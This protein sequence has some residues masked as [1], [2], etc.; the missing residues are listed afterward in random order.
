MKITGVY[1]SGT[2]N[3]KWVADKLREKL[4]V[5]GHEV[6]MCSVEEY[7]IEEM[8]EKLQRSDVIGFLYPGYGCDMP[9]LYEQYLEAL[10]IVRLNKEPKAFSIMTAGMYIADGALITR[11]LCEK[12]GADLMWG[13]VVIMPCNFDTPVPFF[14]IPTDQRIEKM[15][16]K[17]HKKLETLVVNIEE[18][19]RDFDGNDF[20]NLKTGKL[21]RDGWKKSMKNYDIK[22]NESKCISCGQCVKLC[23]AKNLSIEEKGQPV[24]T[25]GNCSVCLR[26]INACPTLAIRMFSKHGSRQFRQYHGPTSK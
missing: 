5:R 11:P 1:F 6:E 18:G 26:C 17:A 2:G 3:T 19:N 8:S 12:I 15:K 25:N 24:K 20:F 10:S 7:S 4:T 9:L 13:N 14:K 23:P 16:R 22:I 21:H